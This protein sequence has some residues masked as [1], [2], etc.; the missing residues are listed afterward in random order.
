MRKSSQTN[1]EAA[2]QLAV[3]NCAEPSVAQPSVFK[4]LRGALYSEMARFSTSNAGAV[5]IIVALA[6]PFMVAVGAS[7]VEYSTLSN[8]KSRLQSALDA[9]ALAATRE[10]S[11]SNADERTVEHVLQSVVA[12]NMP[13]NSGPP[14]LTYSIDRNA[15]QVTVAGTMDVDMA[16]SRIFGMN[17]MPV[18][19]DATAQALGQPNICVLGLHSSSTETIYLGAHS[20]LTGNDCA[21]FSNSTSPS[22]VEANGQSLLTSSTT[23]SAGG[24][25]GGAENFHPMPFVDC[26]HFEDPLSH[27]TP[28]TFSGCDYTDYD[29]G[30][31]RH[32]LNPGVYCGGISVN[33]NAEVTL[34]PGV[35]VIHEGE[36]RVVSNAILDGVGAG[37]YL[38]GADLRFFFGPNARLNLEAPV[39]GEMAGLLFFS[40]RAQSGDVSNEIYSNFVNNMVGTVYLPEAELHV[41][42]SR[43]VANELA[44]TAIVV[45]RLELTVRPHLVLNTDYDE[46]DVPVPDGIRG[47][48]QPIRL[49]D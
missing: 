7:A 24:Y 48:G 6:A 12:A 18:G 43:P 28:P 15:M 44:Y 2:S 25:R 11:L 27:R 17:T 3:T 36:F 38:S 46:T 4:K 39:D 49:I 47:A 42:A 45:K 14:R 16:F 41:K 5:A 8:H 37:F 19:A 21:V 40:D 26:P 10:L 33:G 34:T 23:C 1:T 32:T 31:G 13:D 20:R 9:A 29:V 35:Y 22:G 30:S